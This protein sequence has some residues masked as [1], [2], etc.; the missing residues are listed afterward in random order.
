M[1]VQHGPS[2]FDSCRA[3]GN[4]DRWSLPGDH[5][6]TLVERHLDAGISLY[7]MK[8]GQEVSGMSMLHP[9]VDKATLLPVAQLATD[10]HD[11]QIDTWE[12]ATL[13]VQGRRSVFRFAGIGHD[14]V[15]SRSWSVIL[16]QIKAPAEPTAPDA[17]VQHC[18]YWEREYVLYTAGVP[19]TLTGALRAPV[20]FGTVQPTPH[21]RWMWLEDVRDHYH[22]AWP[23]AH[24]A[25][26]AYH[27]GMLNGHYL[28]HTPIPGEQYLAKH[29]MRCSSGYHIDEFQRYRDPAVWKHPLIQRAY[30]HPVLDTLDR[31]A[32]EREKLLAALARFPQT[33]CH[34]DA[35]HG[36]MAAVDAADR[37]LSTVL[38][39]WALAGYGAPGEEIAPLIWVALLEFQVDSHHAAR[40]EAAVF[41]QY[42]QGLEAAGWQPDPPQVRCAYLIHSIL[43]FGFALEAVDHALDEASYAA[44]E[45]RYGKP[46]EHLVTQAAHVTYLLIERIAELRSVLN[47]GAR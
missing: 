5:T 1:H 22:G 37:S 44:T 4:T 3:V 13:S 11:L 25:Q 30:P 34:L 9:N 40:L 42:L 20:C 27:L 10:C 7:S 33:F 19:Q 35:W 2:S 29:A 26:T 45:Q 15:R 32:A 38:F 17:D 24:Y 31:L 43:R 46:I 41:S 21:L 6:R 14:G 18:A 8:Q 28:V 47:T 23:I 39:D 12:T 16:K 36:N